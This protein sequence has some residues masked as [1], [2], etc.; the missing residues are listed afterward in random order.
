MY[1][2]SASRLDD[3]GLIGD[4]VIRLESKGPLLSTATLDD[5]DPKHN[6]SVLTCAS[7]FPNPKPDEIAEIAILVNG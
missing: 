3:V 5:V 2:A 6:G 4:F 7:A 1:D